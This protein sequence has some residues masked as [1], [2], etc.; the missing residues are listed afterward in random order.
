MVVLNL[1]CVGVLVDWM[2]T[3]VGFSE[4]FFGL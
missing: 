2:K 1:F 4:C 3:V